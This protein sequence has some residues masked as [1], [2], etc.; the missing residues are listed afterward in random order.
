MFE[1][2]R[3]LSA[4]SRDVGRKIRSVEKRMALLRGER[5]GHAPQGQVDAPALS[6]QGGCS[7]NDAIHPMKG[8]AVFSRK[9]HRVARCEPERT[10]WSAPLRAAVAK[11]AGVAKRERHHRG[12]K[13]LFVAILVEPHLGGRAVIIDQTGLGRMRI[14]RKVKPRLEQQIGDRWPRLAGYRVSGL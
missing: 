13:F 4:F 12:G 6:Q 10:R 9:H 7:R 8:K 2:R 14:T 1:S 5:P 11:D 3:L